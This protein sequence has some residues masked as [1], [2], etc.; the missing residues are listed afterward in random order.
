VR[1]VIESFL[2]V[3]NGAGVLSALDGWNFED[4]VPDWPRGNPPGGL[5]STSGLINWHLLYTLGLAAE[6]EEW[7]GAPELA[8]RLRRRQQALGE[9][10]IE[11]F[12]DEGRGLL[13]DDLEREH[14][15]EHTQ[16]LA[17]LSAVLPGEHRQRA[18]AGLLRD[19]TLTRTTIYFTH[20]LFETYRLLRQDAAFFARL[21][22]WLALPGQGFKTTPEKP[23]SSRSDCHGWGA[24]PLYHLFATVLGI[25]PLEF[26][27]G[28]VEIAPL[29]GRLGRVSGSLVHPRGQIDVQLESK[30]S[31]IRG[32]ISLPEGVAGRLRY[33]ETQHELIS[34]RQDVDLP[35]D[36]P[37]AAPR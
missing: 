2:G 4:W 26:G 3:L 34:G 17:L 25:R 11:L 16:C 18:A 6:L 33:G 19:P 35:A 24:H 13:A 22:M 36:E 28:Y 14:F 37:G 9:Q 31:R 5:H 15:S 30:D 1:H 12:W 29:L 7:A 20:Y 21:G 8:L 10:L 32:T 23:E 27:F